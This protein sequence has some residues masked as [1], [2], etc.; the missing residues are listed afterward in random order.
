MYTTTIIFQFVFV[1]LSVVAFT[2]SDLVDTLCSRRHQCEN[3]KNQDYTCENAFWKQVHLI[4][5]KKTCPR[6][7]DPR[8]MKLFQYALWSGQ[9]CSW[10]Q[11]YARQTSLH[12]DSVVSFTVSLWYVDVD[13]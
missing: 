10:A 6:I 9:N 4:H 7:N 13:I 8:K 11:L 3:A 12:L 1:I 2:L 5:D